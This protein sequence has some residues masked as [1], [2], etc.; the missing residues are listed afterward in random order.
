MDRLADDFEVVVRPAWSPASRLRPSL[1]LD[2]GEMGR[3]LTAAFTFALLLPLAAIPAHAQSP[4]GPISAKSGVQVQLAPKDTQAKVK[5]QVALV[6]T[7][8]TVRDGRGEMVHNLEAQDFQITDNGVAQQISHF[9]LGGDPLSMVILLQ[10][11]SRIEPLLP[12]I[13]KTGILFT[14]TVMGPTGEAAVVGFNDSVD[15]L[16]DFTTNADLIENA[17]AHLGQGT[18]GSKL[19]DAMAVGVEMLSGRPQATA[20]KPGRRRVL[21]ILSEATDAGSEAKLGEVLRRAQLVN[22]TIYCVGLSTTRAELQAKA[23]DTRPQITPPGTF[24]LPPQPGTPQTPTSEE[25]RY[26]NIDLM[27]AAVWAVEHIHDQVKDHALEVA[28]T[29]TGGVHLSTFKDRSIEKAIDEIGGE[30]HS[31]YTISYT[32]TG[33][34]AAGYH[35]IKVNIVRNDAKNLKV[36]ARPGYYL[37]TPES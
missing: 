35:E 11:S 25:N 34:D 30:L 6:N 5:V 27:A 1:Y 13:R 14:E 18:S 31:Q 33:S 24:P 16:Q 32:P 9:D 36:R 15:K 2:V 3:F 8:V 17:I 29:A 23:K 10:T 12:Q 26:G 37:A 7:P 21:M 4:A 19:Y 28:A 22:V 20:D